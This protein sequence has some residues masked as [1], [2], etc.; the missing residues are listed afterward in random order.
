[1]RPR[2]AARRSTCS[3]PAPAAHCLQTGCLKVQAP[4]GL[5]SAG[6][7]MS[8]PSQLAVSPDGQN[9]YASDSMGSGGSVDVLDRNPTTGALSDNS[10]V[11]FLPKP[12]PEPESGE[13]GEEDG[14]RGRKVLHAHRSV[15]ERPGPERRERGRRQRRRLVGVR[16]RQWLGGDLLAR[17]QDRQADR[18]L[19]RRRR[20]QSLL[21][22]CRRCRVSA[23]AAVSPDGREVYVV[24]AKSDAV[25]VFGIGASVATTSASRLVPGPRRCACSVRPACDA[26]AAVTSTSPGRRR[27]R[28]SAAAPCARAQAQCRTV[29]PV[30]H[31]AG[32]AGER[33]LR[34]TRA[35]RRVL[36]TVDVCV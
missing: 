17:R 28:P 26:R 36:M 19:V 11:D 34:L 24:A 8:A 3:R 23:Q 20:R 1:M 15:H 22:L 2:P 7:L 33:A 13:E 10:C 5:C 27:A 16:N 12:E 21:E 9:V 4:P 29:R 14:G 18:D 31:P 25:M 6:T 30:L 35:A 32:P